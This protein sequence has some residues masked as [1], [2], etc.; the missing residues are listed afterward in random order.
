MHLD[1]AWRIHSRFFSMQSIAHWRRETGPIACVGMGEGRGGV[2]D[3]GSAVSKRGAKVIVIRSH[4][5][6][7]FA[8]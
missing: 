7:Y 1:D 3:S 2:T 5:L 6:F 4:S 8:R